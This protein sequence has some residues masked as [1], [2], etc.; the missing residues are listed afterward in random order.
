MPVASGSLRGAKLSFHL[1][2]ANIAQPVIAGEWCSRL[3][4]RVGMIW[5]SGKGVGAK[6]SSGKYAITRRPLINPARLTVTG[7][8]AYSSHGYIDMC[9][10]PWLYHIRAFRHPHSC[11]LDSYQRTLC[12][13]KAAFLHHLPEYIHKTAL[14]L[15]FRCGKFSHLRPFVHRSRF[16]DIFYTCHQPPWSG[17]H[18]NALFSHIH[19]SLRRNRVWSNDP[20]DYSVESSS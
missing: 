15:T 20:H 18:L 17:I 1:A 12:I 16:M 8:A 3:E 13:Q 14:I 19:C 5:K 2:R 9:M 6:S 4:P 7:H 11:T 10:V